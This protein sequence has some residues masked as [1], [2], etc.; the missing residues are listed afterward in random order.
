MT[1]TGHIARA[2][3]ALGAAVLV[4]AALQGTPAQAL[5]GHLT[6]GSHDVGH[7]IHP[8]K[9]FGRP[10]PYRGG[11]EYRHPYVYPGFGKHGVNSQ[12]P[13]SHTPG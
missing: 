8:I 7:D 12:K 5:S 11:V 3:L 6:A 1:G 13:P 9:D 4:A 2:G 10:G